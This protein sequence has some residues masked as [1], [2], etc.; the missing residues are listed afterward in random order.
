[1]GE[2]YFEGYID[3]I[4]ADID[5]LLVPASMKAVE[6]LHTYVAAQTPVETGHL[7]GSE[8]VQPATLGA[9]LLIPG[10]YARYQHYEL[11][12][13]HNTGNALYLELPWMSH[14]QEALDVVAGELGKAMD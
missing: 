4:D 7:V 13:H 1:M 14:A 8:D 2:N 3:A 5:A 6:Y 10:P 11:Q 12:L 9:D